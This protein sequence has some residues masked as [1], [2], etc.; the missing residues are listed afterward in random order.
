[1]AGPH[2]VLQAEPKACVE[3]VLAAIG[4][5]IGQSNGVDSASRHEGNI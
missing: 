5:L 2:F 4:H 1:V 3:A